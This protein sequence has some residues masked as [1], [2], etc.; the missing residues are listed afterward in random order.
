MTFEQKA[1]A[2]AASPNAIC[3]HLNLNSCIWLARPW[4]QWM[5]C[6]GRG[7]ARD[8]APKQEEIGPKVEEKK[9]VRYTAKAKDDPADNAVGRSHPTWPSPPNNS[10]RDY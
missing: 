5:R 1:P 10:E 6:L 3:N 2:P 7:F 8:G 4:F 9:D